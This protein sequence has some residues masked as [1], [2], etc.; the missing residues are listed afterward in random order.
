MGTGDGLA[1]PV[2]REFNAATAGWA[3]GF[4]V[5]R[6]HQRDGGLAV[7]AGNFLPQVFRGKC[8]VSVA[9]GAGHF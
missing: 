2:K 4:D 8:D 7:R 1:D 3:G 5:F 6:P 9:Q